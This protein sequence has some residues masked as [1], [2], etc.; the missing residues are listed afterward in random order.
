MPGHGLPASLK[1][2]IAAR[3]RAVFNDTHKG[4]R[5]FVRREDG[6]F[7]PDSVARRV[8]GDVTTMMVGGIAALLLQML[9]PAVLA[10]R[11]L[12]AGGTLTLAQTLRWAFR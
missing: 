2:A 10:S 1:H 6:L 5:P 4:E 3:V 11:P 9:H 8:H 12:V 7:G